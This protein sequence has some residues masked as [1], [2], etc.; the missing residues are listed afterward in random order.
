MTMLFWIADHVLEIVFVL[1]I[2]ALGFAYA[3]WLTRKTRWLIGSGVC[4]GLMLLLFVP[5][6]FIVTDQ[7][8]IRGN[9]DAM[10]NAINAGKAEEA[11]KYFD[12][13]VT[14]ETKS[15]S[16]SVSN[17]ALKD[18]AKG[19][20]NNYKVKQV[21][22]GRVDFETLTDSKAEVSFMVRA[23]DDMSKTGRCQ[24]EFTRTPQGKW[25]V[26]RFTVVAWFGSAKQEPALFPFGSGE[27]K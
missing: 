21:E 27:I 24:M 5:S 8:Q 4:V 22:T 10:R 15:G 13:V 3:W 25:L 19:N 12:D 14:V 1:A 26:K 23:D 6:L 18:Y 20:M 11:A 7:Q 17:K 16:F 2:V 9:I